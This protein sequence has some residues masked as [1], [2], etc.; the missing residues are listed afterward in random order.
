MRFFYTVNPG[1]DYVEGRKQPPAALMEAMGPYMEKAIAAGALISTAGLKPASLGTT[2]TA[3]DGKI[4][5]VDGPYAEAKELIGGYAVMEAPDRETALRLARDFVQLH[6]DHGMTD[7]SVE[8][9][10]I[11]GGYNY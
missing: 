11:E 10:E 9:R 8:M 4:T 3:R 7:I 5:T 1:M 6:V 2:V